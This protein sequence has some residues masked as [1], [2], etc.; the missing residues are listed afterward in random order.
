MHRDFKSLKRA[1][2]GFRSI[3]RSAKSRIRQAQN[4]KPVQDNPSLGSENVPDYITARPGPSERP[5][6]SGVDLALGA[7]RPSSTPTSWLDESSFHQKDELDV[8]PVAGYRLPSRKAQE[9]MQAHRSGQEH[10]CPVT[11]LDFQGCIASLKLNTALFFRSN[12]T[13]VNGELIM[14]IDVA[15][16]AINTSFKACLQIG[17]LDNIFPEIY[18]KFSRFCFNQAG[19]DLTLFIQ[20]PN[21]NAE[22][23]AA[24]IT[25]PETK[26]RDMRVT[27]WCNLGRCEEPYDHLRDNNAGFYHDPSLFGDFRTISPMESLY[28]KHFDD[29]SPSLFTDYVSPQGRIL[30]GSFG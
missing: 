10:G 6:T 25:N 1:Y 3:Y 14:K 19:K 27:L 28:M 8:P 12:A 16:R 30:T 17:L 13:I 4:T 15:K 5:M 29:T 11:D 18:L 23:R 9:V 24:M 22:V 26:L 7:F 21:S 20:Y 2:G